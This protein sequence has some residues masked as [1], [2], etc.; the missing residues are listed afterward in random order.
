MKRAIAVLALVL[1]AAACGTHDTTPRATGI[2]ST[3][4]PPTTLP[5]V[6][7][8]PEAKVLADCRTLQA[9][10]EEII[11]ACADAGLIVDGLTWDTWAAASATGA[12][13]VHVNLCDP[14]CAEGN[15]LDVPARVELDQPVQGTFSELV[16][17]WEGDPPFGRPTDTYALPT[18]PLG[19]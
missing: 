19:G 3:T 14:N 7:F 9:R 8:E 2:P 18:E 11:G 12:G 17:T 10:P 15:V 13:T 1:V 5:P 16:V 4:A 6:S